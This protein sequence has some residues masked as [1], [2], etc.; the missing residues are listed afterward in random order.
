MSVEETRDL[1]PVS[2]TYVSQ[3]LNLH[4]L[5]WGNPGAPLIVLVHGI[6]E[7]ARS[8]DQ[9][10]RAL[11]RDW[12]VVAPDLRGHGDSVWSPDR[13]YLSAYY[14]LDI[15]S[16]AAS[17]NVQKMCVVAHSLGGNVMARFTALFPEQVTKLVL[18]E[19]LGPSPDAFAN[20]EKQGPVQRTRAWIDAQRT[21]PGKP[22][23]VFESIAEVQ[24]RLMK[25]NPRLKPELA[26]YLAHHAVRPSAHGFAWKHDPLVNAF[27][28][29]D[30]TLGGALF[31]KEIAIPTL[32]FQGT[33]SWTSNPETDGRAA[34]FRNRRTVVV[35]GAGHWVHHDR[36][37][38][39]I[40]AL[41]AFL[42][43]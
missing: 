30:F 17:L 5:D 36:F 35:E 27:A 31:W 4:Y 16:L 8:W 29:E 41:Q 11:C 23:R 21:F 2:R 24:V 28:P 6:C 1:E 25:S 37:E 38:V 22:A 43:K 14:L 19:G 42:S 13:A 9:T 32:L 39:F 33:E 40:A 12:H 34:H 7:H 3:G 18:V 20:W 15:A 26:S 10:A